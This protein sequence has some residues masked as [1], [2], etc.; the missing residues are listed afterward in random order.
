MFRKKVEAS[1][2]TE[3][4]QY[5]RW[6]AYPLEDAALKTELESIA[7]KEEEIKHQHIILLVLLMICLKVLQ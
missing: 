5:D 7:G 2:M 4:M 3:K 1:F 6:L